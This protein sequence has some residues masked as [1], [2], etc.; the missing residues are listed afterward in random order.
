MKYT[1][2]PYVA[3][4]PEIS[5]RVERFLEFIGS[6]YPDPACALIHLNP[7]EL[8]CATILS[9]QCTDK[10]VNKVTPALFAEY[11]TPERLA[12]GD[13]SKVEELIKSTGFYHNKAKSLISMADM[14]M[15]K[16]AGVIPNSLEEL[17]KLPGVG[18]KTANVLLGNAFSVPAMVVDT[19][20][21]RISN[22]LAFADTLDPYKVELALVKLIDKSRWVDFSHQVILLGR[23]L[24]PARS[25]RC[26]SCLMAGI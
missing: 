22:K 2:C 4:C 26:E 11:P 19:H 16:H 5:P 7:F 17:E 13:I 20:V 18:R 12:K 21:L 24:C 10:Q 9:A 8:L 3:L 23:D 14:V 15:K 25:P 1:E 6:R